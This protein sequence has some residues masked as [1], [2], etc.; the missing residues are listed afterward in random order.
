M[1]LF[2]ISV[3]ELLNRKAF[4]KCKRYILEWVD[5]IVY[6]YLYTFATTAVWSW[7]LENSYTMTEIITTPFQKRDHLYNYINL[8]NIW[9]NFVV[10]VGLFC[11]FLQPKWWYEFYSYNNNSLLFYNALVSYLRKYGLLAV[12]LR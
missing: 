2:E 12:P 1:R 5:G 6:P 11:N 9:E 4:T 3:V 7:K 10:T 8:Y